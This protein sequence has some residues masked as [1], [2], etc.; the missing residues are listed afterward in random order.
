[1]VAGIDG[2]NFQ[3]LS[4]ANQ[5]AARNLLLDLSGSV[6]QVFESFTL[7]TPQDLTFY[8]SPDVLNNRHINHQNEFSGFVKDDWKA[9]SSLTLNLGLHYEWYGAPYEEHGLAGVPVGGPAALKCGLSCGL[10]TM[11][12]VGK[13]SPHPDFRTNRNDWNNVGPSLGF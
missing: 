4:A 8:G 13:N 11:Q 7:K 9:S 3:G 5:N 12:F 6:G 1:A 2:T 10:I